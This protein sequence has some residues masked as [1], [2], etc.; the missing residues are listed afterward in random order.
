MGEGLVGA[1]RG[2][3]ERDKRKPAVMAEPAVYFKVPSLDFNADPFQALSEKN[4]T[5]LAEMPT[6]G[7]KSK[8]LS[9]SA[10]TVTRMRSPA[11][12][13]DCAGSIC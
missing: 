10:L 3:R 6:R 11:E 5:V 12:R 8:F 9:P 1:E 13:V 4:I 2:Q 7:T